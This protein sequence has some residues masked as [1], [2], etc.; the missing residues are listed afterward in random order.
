MSAIYDI[1]VTAIDGTPASLRAY[2]GKVLLIVNVA[3]QCGF[4]PQYA[5]L[6]ELYRAK[7]GDGLVVLGFP[8]N[9]FGAQEPG[10][11]AEIAAFCST[12]YDVGFPL[13]A[14]I[15]VQE[16]DRHPLYR[17]LIAARPHATEKADGS[18]ARSMAGYGVSR[19]DPS[20]VFWNFEKFVVGRDGNVTAR[21]TSDYAPDDPDLVAALDAELSKTA[22]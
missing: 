18:F 22:P 21:F 13:F 16:P 1:P 4:T 17:A 3:S 10:S 5:G 11:N 9:D 14:K 7:Q 2:A 19:N 15:S 12:S 8:A 20:D 6:Q